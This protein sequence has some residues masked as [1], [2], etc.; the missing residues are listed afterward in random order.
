MRDGITGPQG[1]GADVYFDVE[2]FE[3]GAA[4]AALVTNGPREGDDYDG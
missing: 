1:G 3:A 2:T 4:T